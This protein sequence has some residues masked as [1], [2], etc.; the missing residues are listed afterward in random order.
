MLW[1]HQ[2][3]CRAPRRHHG[4]HEHADRDPRIVSQR[5]RDWHVSSRGR[6][7]RLEPRGNAGA[8]AHS[9]GPDGEDGIEA[10]GPAGGIRAAMMP[11][12]APT[13]TR[14]R[15]TRALPPPDCDAAGRAW[16]A[17]CQSTPINAPALLRVALSE[18][19]CARMSRRAHPVPCECRS[20]SSARRRDQHDVHDHD[21]AHHQPDGREQDAREHEIL[22][23]REPCASAERSSPARSCPFRT[24]AAGAGCASA[25]ARSLRA[26]RSCRGSA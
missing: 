18:E 11:M 22:L 10:R 21:R 9:I 17:R 2:R 4:D 14:G 6:S 25:R 24:D 1:T 16:R 3:L 23:D 13:P 19:N 20:R 15:S 7:R 12:L 8:D 5:A 26:G